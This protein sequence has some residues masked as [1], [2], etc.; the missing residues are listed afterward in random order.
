MMW[1]NGTGD[2]GGEKSPNKN[3]CKKREGGVKGADKNCGGLEKGNLVMEKGP[4]QTAR[5]LDCAQDEAGKIRSCGDK[6]GNRKD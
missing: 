4:I 2:V 5:S 1:G 6:G 3:H